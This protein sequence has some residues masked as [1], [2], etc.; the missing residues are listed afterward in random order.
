MCDVK[1]SSERDRE[2]PTFYLEKKSK[3]ITI[4][5]TPRKGETYTNPH[6]FSLLL[7]VLTLASLLTCEMYVSPR[8]VCGGVNKHEHAHIHLCTQPQTSHDSY[9]SA[10]RHLDVLFE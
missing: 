10:T 6:G 4:L 9:S 2:T 7:V 8:K 5:H 3:E 1:T